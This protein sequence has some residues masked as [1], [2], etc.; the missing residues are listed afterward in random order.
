M[1]QPESPLNQSVHRA[2]KIL[3]YLAAADG[4]KD[5]AVISRSVQLNKSTV[6]RFLTTLEEDQY[7]YQDA[8]TGRYSLGAKVTWLSAKFLEKNEIRNVA[9]PLLEALAVRTGETAH[10]GILDGDEVCYIDKINGDQAVLMAS[11]VGIRMP[12]HCTALGKVLLASEP[13][14]R[15]QQYVDEYGLPPRTARTITHPNRFFE[16]LETVRRQRFAWDELE[17]EDGIRCVA[18]P[19]RDASCEVVAAISV[20]GWIIT[21]TEARLRQITPWVCAAAEAISARLGCEATIES[22]DP[23]TVEP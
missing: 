10:L 2:I 12:L 5:L 18:A 22:K 8:V 9:H 20:S 14:A 1:K 16:E 13:V 7:V 15:W 4:P 6:Y 11:R 17:N 19:I 3:E 23:T 21:M